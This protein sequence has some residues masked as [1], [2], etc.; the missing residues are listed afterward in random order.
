MTDKQQSN[1]SVL[2]QAQFLLLLSQVAHIEASQLGNPD[3]ELRATPGFKKSLLLRDNFQK[4]H[5]RVCLK[6]GRLSARSE[7]ARI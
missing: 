3:I 7:I 6:K 2:L 4:S 5:P 1:C